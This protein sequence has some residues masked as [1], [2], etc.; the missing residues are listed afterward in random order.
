MEGLEIIVVWVDD[1]LLFA[2][3]KALMTKMKSELQS[4]FEITDLG[5]PTRIV[6]I[7]IDRD[8]TKNTITISQKQYLQ[9]ILEKEGMEN[10]NPVGMPMD[11]GIQLNLPKGSQRG[12]MRSMAPKVLHP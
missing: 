4:I 10:A 6:G 3:N 11:P 5:E 12:I 7:E 9:M 2:S 8:C 1:L